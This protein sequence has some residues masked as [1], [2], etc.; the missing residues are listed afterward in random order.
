MSDL[1]SKKEFL[2]SFQKK[3]SRACVDLCFEQDHI[4]RE[5]L[6]RCFSKFVSTMQTTTSH[7]LEA[8]RLVGSEYPRR[9]KRE[10]SLF[11]DLVYSEAFVTYKFADP[12]EAQA[13]DKNSRQGR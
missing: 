8:G 5:C 1:Q 7:M 10:Q 6:D 13:R 2:D 3:L 9:L 4:K 12:S 11:T